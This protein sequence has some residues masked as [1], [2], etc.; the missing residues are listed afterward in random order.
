MCIHAAQPES[1][2]SSKRGSLTLRSMGVKARGGTCCLIISLIFD[3]SVC[4]VS[5][6]VG[7]YNV[8]RTIQERETFRL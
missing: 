3:Y 5:E 8:S 4:T 1:M 7:P 2:G 6:S